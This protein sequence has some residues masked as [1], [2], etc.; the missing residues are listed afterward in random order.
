MTNKRALAALLSGCCILGLSGCVNALDTGNA[1]DSSTLFTAEGDDLL[2]NFDED[3]GFQLT[4]VIASSAAFSRVGLRFDATGPVAV[5]VRTSNDGA[6]SFS[7]WMPA[8]LTFQEGAANNA[9]VDVA[10]PHSTHLQLRFAAPVESQ[11]TFLAVDAFV[12]DEQL[13]EVVE[14]AGNETEQG[15]STSVVSRD[16]WGARVRNCNS[17]HTPQKITIHHTETPTNDGMSVAA[18]LRQIQS[19]HIDVRGWCDIGYHFLVGSD[20]NIYQGRKETNLGA[21]VSGANTNNVGISFIGSFQTNAPS[22]LMQNAAVGLLQ[23]LQTAYGISLDRSHVKTHRE[24]GSTD[25]PGN[26]LQARID[27]LLQM[28]G[29][30]TPVAPPDEE[31]PAEEPTEEEPATPA[32]SCAQVQVSGASTLNV[33]PTAST[34]RS[35]IGTVS[36]GDIVNVVGVEPNGQAVNSTTTWYEVRVSSLQGFIS[37]A[38]ARCLSTSPPPPPAPPDEPAPPSDD[39]VYDG[40]DRGTA[41]IPRAGLSNDTLR[42]AL[43][44]STEPYGSIFQYEG[45]DFVRGKV[46]HFGGP[47]DTG[48]SST[49]TG[50][51]TGERLR[52]L[53]SPLN[54][55]DATIATRPADFYFIAMRWDY[56]PHGRS[57]WVNARI[58]VVNP[59]NG[60]KVVLRPVDWGPNTNTRRILDIS[61]EAISDLG[62]STDDNLLVSFAAPGTPLGVQ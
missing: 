13:D 29:N 27:T 33:R 25:C 35:P 1:G 23:S 56:T 48:V 37:G 3:A 38:Y 58:L 61:P 14:G 52:S 30:Q 4:H 34:A 42:N 10:T 51:V 40:I 11:L 22:T 21:H 24:Q 15:L 62:A 45:N 32:P 26:A 19:Y 16:A 6:A 50:A 17:P 55:S 46:S 8:T 57:F 54:A 39:D 5:E 9:Y 60:V 31:E 2:D 18:R 41:Q 53:N 7:G 49:E 36:D 20:G 28:A 43:G 59:A 44:V 12:L 47:N